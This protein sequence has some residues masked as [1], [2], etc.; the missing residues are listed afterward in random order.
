M[1]GEHLEE[2]HWRKN[3]QWFSLTRAHAE[4]V[5][6]DVDVAAAFKRCALGLAG[7][8]TRA[9]KSAVA[10]TSVPELS[11]PCYAAANCLQE[12]LRG[13]RAAFLHAARVMAGL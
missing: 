13:G 7:S 3:G 10:E 12:P 4:L 6:A 5:V 1:A 11:Y 9:G 2:A 8:S